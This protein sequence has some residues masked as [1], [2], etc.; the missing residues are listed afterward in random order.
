V[1][2]ITRVRSLDQRLLGLEP[3][4]DDE[5]AL[6]FVV[7]P[8]LCRGDGRFYGGAALAASLAASEAVT[9]RPTLWSS[10]QLVATADL[11]ERIRVGVE[12]VASGRSV[13][14]VDV[15]ATVGDRVIFAAVGSNGSPRPGGLSG[16]GQVM[17]RVA[18]P[19][20]AEPWHGPGRIAAEAEGEP[21]FMLPAVG[22]HLVSEHREAPLLD[23]S[24]GRPGH[25]ALWARLRGELGEAHEMTPAGLGFLADMVPIACARACGVQGAGTSLD[26]SLRIGD[27]VDTE[28]VLL[29]LDA[30]VAVGGYGHGHVHVWSPDGRMLATGTQSAI[31][32]SV[33][34]M[35]ARRAARPG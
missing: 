27:V 30:H 16:P 24:P 5:D 11:G 1:S 20:D 23:G 2:D 26:N 14:Q 32:F 29:E 4:P 7:V 34:D 21:T 33:D 15:R 31:L 22:H 9:G 12:V 13:D 28:W 35:R 17:P 3:D 25:M 10:T 8:H 6:S 19:D 18:P